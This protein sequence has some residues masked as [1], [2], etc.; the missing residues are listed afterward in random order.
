[1]SAESGVPLGIAEEGIKLAQCGIGAFVAPSEASVLEVDFL[2]SQVCNADRKRLI[3]LRFTFL[4]F[5]SLA[6]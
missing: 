6:R 2:E 4:L 3:L 1:M 5:L